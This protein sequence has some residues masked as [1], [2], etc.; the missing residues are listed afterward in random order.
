MS[1]EVDGKCVAAVASR[2]LRGHTC[3]PR[4]TGA[5]KEESSVQRKAY[6]QDEGDARL[7]SQIDLSAAVNDRHLVARRRM[8]G[9]VRI[10]RG[11]G[12]ASLTVDLATSVT[13]HATGGC[14]CW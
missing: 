9:Q 10:P 1:F 8:Q 3:K 11:T 5:R 14:P 6:H 4:A 13:M 7:L 2:F 12:G